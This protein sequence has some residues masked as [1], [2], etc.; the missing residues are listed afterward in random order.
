MVY[1]VAHI[2]QQLHVLLNRL[3]ALILFRQFP[4]KLLPFLLQL[5][6]IVWQFLL[7]GFEETLGGKVGV[8]FLPV[9]GGKL[10]LPCFPADGSVFLVN[11]LVGSVVG[12]MGKGGVDGLYPAFRFSDVG[13][14]GKYLPADLIQIGVIISPI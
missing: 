3:Q 1:P 7:M 10:L 4:G 11:F 14:G 2:P 8:Q 9:F 5:F 6:R 13:L 12:D